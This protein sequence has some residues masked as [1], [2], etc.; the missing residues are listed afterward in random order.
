MPYVIDGHNLIGR[1]PGI[2]LEDP[3]DE[4]KLLEVLEIFA[5]FSRHKVVVF[6]DRGMP[7]AGPQFQAGRMLTAHFVLPPRKADDAIFDF[8][9]GHKDARGYTVVSSDSEVCTRARRAGAKVVAS[10]EYARRV[11]A[12]VRK[13]EKEKPSEKPADIEEWLRL[14]GG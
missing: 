14:F 9:R 4:R 11:R 2:E 5:R 6:F 13:R 8:L 7:G 10:E 12:L 1:F 3:E